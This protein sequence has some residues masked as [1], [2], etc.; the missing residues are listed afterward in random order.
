MDCNRV[1]TIDCIRSIRSYSFSLAALKASDNRLTAASWMAFAL[2]AIIGNRILSIKRR[3]LD[4][5]LNEKVIRMR[6]C[7]KVNNLSDERHF[8]LN[9][10]EGDSE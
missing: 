9:W 7:E 6:L 10:K 2:N 5:N 1:H 8:S 3:R 4:A